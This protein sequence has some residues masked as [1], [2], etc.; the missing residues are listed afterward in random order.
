MCDLC[1]VSL[2]L[3]DEDLELSK[4]G[5][6]ESLVAGGHEVASLLVGTVT[7]LGHT[8]GT[9]ETTAHSTVNTLGLAPGVSNALIAVRVVT[10][11]LLG[12]LLYDFGVAQAGGHTCE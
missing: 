8:D 1:G 9:A 10:L 2:G 4:V 11:E 6:K 12:M 3:E 7:D 5:D